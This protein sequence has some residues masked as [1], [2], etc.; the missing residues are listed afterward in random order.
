MRTVEQIS[1]PG[2]PVSTAKS[3]VVEAGRPGLVEA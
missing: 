3:F 2:A 1:S